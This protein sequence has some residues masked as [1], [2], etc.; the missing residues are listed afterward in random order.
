MLLEE[1]S[2]FQNRISYNSHSQE[3][4][5]MDYERN[6]LCNFMYQSVLPDLFVMRL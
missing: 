2:V 6:A 5:W 1:S 4:F 3:P